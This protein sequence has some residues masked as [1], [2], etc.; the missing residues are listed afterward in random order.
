MFKKKYIIKIILILIGSFLY[1]FS[2]NSVFIPHQLMSGGISGVAIFLHLIFG[3]DTALMIVILN[4]PV[5]LLGYKFTDRKFIFF[6]I[7][8]MIG[9]SVTYCN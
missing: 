9:V 3:I 6:S 2:M 8:G 5:F 1:G 4:I 7:I